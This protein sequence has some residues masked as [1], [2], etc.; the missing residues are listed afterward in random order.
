MVQNTEVEK[1]THKCAHEDADEGQ[2]N[3]REEVC[4][5]MGQEE[6]NS[7]NHHLQTKH[8]TQKI[9]PNSFKGIIILC[10]SYKH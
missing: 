5:H 1:Q 6:K 7:K 8:L 3:S 10:K 4:Q 2:N 9:K